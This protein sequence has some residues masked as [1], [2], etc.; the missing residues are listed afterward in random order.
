MTREEILH[1]LSR[2]VVRVTS[3]PIQASSVRGDARLRQDMGLG[4]MD[5]SELLFEV[6]EAF[7][8]EIEDTEAQEIQTVDDVVGLVEKKVVV[9]E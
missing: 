1:S 3:Q 4:S 5:L 7:D 8:I 6:E 9:D 2:I